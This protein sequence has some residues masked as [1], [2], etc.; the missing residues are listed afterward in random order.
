MGGP[1][2]K[3][4]I[5]TQGTPLSKRPLASGSWLAAACPASSNITPDSSKRAIG[6]ARLGGTAGGA[7]DV[8]GADEE[9]YVGEPGR[10][11][12]DDGGGTKEGGSESMV[13]PRRGGS[14]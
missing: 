9:R 2:I 12:S 10:G 13:C 3:S 11:G 4:A 1:A 5:N 7:T 14:A 8:V 6:Q